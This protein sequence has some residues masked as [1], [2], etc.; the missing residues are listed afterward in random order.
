MSTYLYLCGRGMRKRQRRSRERGRKWRET[1]RIVY[2]VGFQLALFPLSF[3]SAAVCVGS[4][5]LQRDYTITT[6]F[7]FFIKTHFRFSLRLSRTI[8]LFFLYYFIKLFFCYWPV[9][10]ILR[11]TVGKS[12]IYL[13]FFHRC[14]AAF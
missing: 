7:F 9:W 13:L 6:I 11:I 1:G 2:L 10:K 3:V 4:L 12:K 5:W 8:Y 14:I